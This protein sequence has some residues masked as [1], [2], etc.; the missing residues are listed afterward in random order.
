MWT[1]RLPELHKVTMIK[2]QVTIKG[3]I[4]EAL[5]SQNTAVFK[6]FLC[7]ACTLYVGLVRT[8]LTTNI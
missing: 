5:D 4:I 2:V 8:V 6:H 1:E 3:D 7:L